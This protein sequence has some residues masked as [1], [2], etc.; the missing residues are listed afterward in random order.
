[1]L[2]QYDT[3]AAILGAPASPFVADFVGADR[4]LKRL[5]VTGIDPSDLE[6]PPVVQVDDTLAE[7]RRRLGA[8]AAR[9]AVVLDGAGTLH[10]WLGRDRS[11]GEG[12]VRDRARRMDAWVPATASLKTAFAEMLTQDAGW[13]A[14]L[15]G[16]RYLGVLTPD[17]LH[18][19]LRRSVAADA[20]E[21]ADAAG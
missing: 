5:S 6:T 9:W 1:V 18:A 19:A 11:E 15:D 20:A 7:A 3:P 16:N 8:Q 21:A 17:S 4:G 13:I 10:G 12:L 2:A 14:V